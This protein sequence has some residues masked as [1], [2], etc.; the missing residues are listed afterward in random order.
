VSHLGI[1][2]EP[3]VVFYLNNGIDP[4]TIGATGIYEINFENL[5]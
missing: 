4:I 3:G 1:Q 2:G 5:G